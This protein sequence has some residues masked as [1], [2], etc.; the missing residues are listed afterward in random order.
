MKI[1]VLF[2]LF[3]ICFLTLYSF[4]N[5][6]KKTYEAGWKCGDTAECVYGGVE[7]GLI[8]DVRSET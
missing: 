6:V 8:L 2:I 5:K 3:I 4:E 7:I 1:K